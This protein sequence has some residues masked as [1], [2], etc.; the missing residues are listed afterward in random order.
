MERAARD[1]AEIRGNRIMN[2]MRP[3]IIAK[4]DQLNSDD[5]IGRT[6][7]IRITKVEVRMDEQ[8]VSVCYEGDNGKPYKPGK[9]MRRVLV[10]AWGPDASVY[11]G[12]SLT[13][14]RDDKVKFGGLDVGGIRISHM[15]HIPSEMT[16]ALT[17]TRAQRKPFTV[18]P[19]AEAP[20]RMTTRE[21]LVAVV[22]ELGQ[23]DAEVELEAI[24]ARDQVKKARASFTNGAHEQ[25]E[26]AIKEAQERLSE[27]D[28]FDD[29]GSAEDPADAE[30]VE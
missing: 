1:R 5:L 12:R 9:S 8:P 6:L 18:K 19:L 7:T 14:Y 29:D 2:D 13:L 16:M 30:A 21:W 22:A 15:S 20:R 11:V 24:L 17:V 23:V 28:S 26:R 27:P 3:T 25:L 10:K 4:S